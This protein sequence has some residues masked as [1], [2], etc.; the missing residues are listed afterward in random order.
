M[1]RPII[2][3]KVGNLKK[4]GWI[5]VYA[6]DWMIGTIWGTGNVEYIGNDP[7]L[8]GIYLLRI[9]GTAAFIYVDAIERKV[10]AP[11]KRETVSVGA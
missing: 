5:D 8:F 6:D 7:F 3:A 10:I 4:N 1:E 11:I 2:T 9:N